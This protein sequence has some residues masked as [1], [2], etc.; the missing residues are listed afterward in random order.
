MRNLIARLFI[1]TVKKF[2]TVF[3][4]EV[5]RGLIG[6]SS[7]AGALQQ[8]KDLGFTPATVIDVGASTGTFTVSCHGVFPEAR[9]LLIEPLEENRP[10]LKLITKKIPGA[11]YVM[12]V[13]DARSGER[14]LNVHCDLVGSSL[15]QEKEANLD[16]T[17]RNV[18]AVTIDDICK[19][20]GARAPYL[21]KIDVQGAELNV[22]AGAK[23]ILDK[24]EY[25]ILE[26]SLFQFVKGG[27]EF[28]DVVAFMKSREFVA[29]D[30]FG[31]HYRPLDGAMA[32]IDI[33]FVKDR[34]R[35]RNFHVYTTPLQREKLT[36]SILRQR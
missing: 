33:A 12:A 9:Y 29:Y 24:T 21:I 6:R 15:Y 27:P 26:V 16:G 20:R 36:K 23:K 13:A 5:R 10:A 32:Q 17:P 30:M 3:G 35:F 1:K 31:Y 22:L 14:I 25:L 2:F 18:P 8:I 19:K 34:S 28:F 7:F 4:L 11:E